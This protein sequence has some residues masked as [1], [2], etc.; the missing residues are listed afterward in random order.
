M[1]WKK[2]G[3]AEQEGCE[4]P[5]RGCSCEEG[6]A[7]VAWLGRSGSCAR[8]RE[9]QSRQGSSQRTGPRA[10]GLGGEGAPSE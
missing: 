5:R 8:P 4:P 7:W 1:L 6:G 9:K 10:A 2:G 3:G